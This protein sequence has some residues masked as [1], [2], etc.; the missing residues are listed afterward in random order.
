MAGNNGK[1]ILDLGCGN[2]KREGAVGV[3]INTKTNPDIVHDLNKLP[4]PFQTSTFEEIYMDNVI[5][6]LEDVIKVVEELHRI[7][8]P[9]GLVK[10]DVPYF[11]AHWAFIDPTHKHFFTTQSFSY[12][13]PKHVHSKLFPYS[14][15]A[16]SV[17]KVVF[18][19]KIQTRGFRGL[20]K[21]FAN[22]YPNFY[23]HYIGALFPMD[24]LSFYLRI[25]K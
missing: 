10:I 17:E 1:K 20:M 25:I 12:F 24:E 23:E 13:D 3:D 22:R 21:R 2:R 9:N 7:G 5:E 8:A 16:F 15:A 14:N 4:Y 18:N 6:H 11:R 19:E